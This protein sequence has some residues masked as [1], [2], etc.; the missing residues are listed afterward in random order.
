MSLRHAPSRCR[1]LVSLVAGALVLTTLPLTASAVEFD[2]NDIVFPVI[3]DVYYSDTYGAPRSGG[4]SHEGTDIMS[5]DRVKGRPVVAVADGVVGW[6]HDEQGGNCCAMSIRH[7]GGWE[8]R[9]IHLDN[10]TPGTDDGQGWGFADGI[11][12]GATVTQ[13]Q[14]IGWLGDSGNAEGTAPHLH[15][16]IRRD[17]SAI[18]SYPYLINAP[19]LDEPGEFTWDGTFWDDD[20]SVHAGDIDKIAARGITKGCNPPSNSRYCPERE[21]T[22]G[23]MAAFIRRTLELP[24][25]AEDYFDDDS[26]D[27][28]EGDINAITAAGIGFGCTAT[29]YCSNQPLLREEMAEMLVRAFEYPT[30][31]TDYF[32]DDES[33]AFEPA[34]NALAAVAVTKGCNPPDNDNFC[35]TRALTR[36]EMASF[37]VRALGL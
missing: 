5:V 16:E 31:E 27:I 13:G 10:D 25:A 15:F 20:S 18:N 32:T 30:V 37:F 26:G 24:S 6:M 34:I 3:G 12:S 11:V 19:V 1:W 21:I 8:T 4:R 9:Y 36:A 17:G 23:E 33:S 35:P 28:F 14:L 29:A 22:R 7:E 2:P